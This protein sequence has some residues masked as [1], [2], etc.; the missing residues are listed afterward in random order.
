MALSANGLRSLRQSWP[1]PLDGDGTVAESENAAV[2]DAEVNVQDR[3]G[4]G[5]EKS[6]GGR[7]R[8]ARHRSRRY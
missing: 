8:T 2:Q 1:A 4:G 7:A 6:F 5:D 3:K